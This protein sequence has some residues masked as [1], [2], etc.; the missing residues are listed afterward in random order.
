MLL[1]SEIAKSLLTGSRP[2]AFQRAKGKVH[3]YT[4]KYSTGWLK[5]QTHR[6][7]IGKSA[8]LRSYKSATNVCGV[9]ST[10]SNGACI[11]YVVYLSA[12]AE[13]LVISTVVIV[14]AGLSRTIVL[15]IDACTVY[16]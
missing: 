14:N 16:F 6:S 4:R 5:T 7:V 11:T 2:R 13:L 10:K 3:T 9:P 8:L 1:S 15:C 12:L